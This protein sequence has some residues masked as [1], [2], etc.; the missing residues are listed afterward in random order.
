MI[1]YDQKLM[2]GERTKPPFYLNT[3]SYSMVMS[4]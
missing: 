3:T 1:F 4:F 2:L